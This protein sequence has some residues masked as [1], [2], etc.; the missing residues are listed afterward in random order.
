MHILAYSDKLKHKQAYPQAYSEPCNSG[1]FRTQVY[2]EPAAYSEPWYI[3]NPGL[4]RTLVYSEPWYVPN[5]GIFR[6]L[7]YSEPWCIQNPGVLGTL[8]Y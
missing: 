2:S 1:I 4:F 3:Q 8:A 5:P 6:T 7:V